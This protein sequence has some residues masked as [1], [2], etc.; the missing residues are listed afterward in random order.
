VR[1]LP[2]LVRAVPAFPWSRPR[3]PGRLPTAGEAPTLIALARQLPPRLL[4]LALTHSS[5]VDTRTES[6]ERLEFLGDSVLGLAIA[7]AL[8][9]RFPESDE[10]DMARVKAFVVS[11][12]SCVQVAR[13]LGL[14]ELLIE[15]APAPERKRREA[16]DNP[17][18]QGNVL[19]ALIGAVYLTHGFEQTRGAV[20]E[21]FEQQIQYAVTAHVDN[22][23]TLQELLAPRGL[24]P[25]YRLVAEAGPPH[26]RV[27]TSEVL[28]GGSLSG[29]GTGTTIKMS[30]QAAAGEALASLVTP[31]GEGKAT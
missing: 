27:F 28:V 10:G 9:Q 3:R 6:Y 21:A 17:T 14:E 16:A 23:T 29:R 31:L 30:E 11:R 22:K 2:A 1:G 4:E 24:Q 13:A 19:E 25:V 15:Q 8:Y 7:S 20:I 5:W 12:T 18:I 26:A